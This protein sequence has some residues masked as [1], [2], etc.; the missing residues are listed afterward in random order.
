MPEGVK[1]SGLT[2]FDGKQ[3]T[4]VVPFSGGDPFGSYAYTIQT[5]LNSGRIGLT[6][7][8][9]SN[10]D[11]VETVDEAPLQIWNVVTTGNLLSPYQLQSATTAQSLPNIVHPLDF[12]S[13]DNPKIFQI[14]GYKGTQ[15]V[16]TGTTGD[17]F[18]EY[19]SQSVAPATPTSA[20]RAYA[21]SSGRPSWI[22]SDGYTRTFSSTLTANRVYTFPDAAGTF[23]LN[24]NPAATVVTNIDSI[25]ATAA[26]SLTLS[27]G[28]TGASLVLGQGASAIATL[29]SGTGGAAGGITF[30]SPAISLVNGS[31]AFLSTDPVVVRI[32][33]TGNGGVA[34]PFLEAGHLVLQSRDV[35]AVRDVI[36][37]NGNPGAVQ[38]VFKGTGNLLIGGTTDITGTGGLKVFGTTAATTTATG[39]LIVAGGAGISGSLYAGNVTPM[40]LS[41]VIGN[42]SRGQTCFFGDAGGSNYMSNGW[43]VYDNGADNRWEWAISTVVGGVMLEM[44]TTGI[45]GVNVKAVASITAGNPVSFVRALTVAE[46]VVT[47]TPSTAAESTI[48]GA[49]VVT[50]GVGVGGAVYA[51][52]KSVISAGTAGADI[53]NGVLKLIGGTNA[54]LSNITFFNGASSPNASSRNWQISSNYS[55]FGTLDILRSSTSTGNP[56][57]QA[58]SFNSSGDF[59]ISSS[60]AS[61]TATSGALM[62][63][64]GAGVLGAVF[65][66]GV[67]C[68]LGNTGL[69]ATVGSQIVMSPAESG[70]YNR[71]YYGNGT[72]YTLGF[73]IR[74]TGT[75][76]DR[77]TLTDGG[78]MTLTAATISISPTTGT[79]VVQ[80]LVG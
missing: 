64:G 76:T 18:V 50:G 27:G 12:N 1:I 21:D 48:T 14:L 41:A 20:L 56:T 42:A 46:T 2:I 16:L 73:A 37:A 15:F 36:I 54:D 70:A 65:T 58:A 3:M 78:V 71:I 35:G 39:A 33:R 9:T 51:G 47:V 68:V 28:T 67:V 66:G 43:V 59:T 22:Q 45:F 72:G 40:G 11:G 74:N 75:T 44:P 23:L 10:L 79:L 5:L 26:T 29:T 7:G 30:V 17:G 52:K 60:T 38:A 32:F 6:G 24:T 25:T 55:T 13:G 19:P 63:G 53:S 69:P 49:L 77:V 34:Y 8:G 80:R 61:T 31:S 62:V 4:D 57:T